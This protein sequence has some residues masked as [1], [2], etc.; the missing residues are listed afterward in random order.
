MNVCTEITS[1]QLQLFVYIGVKDEDIILSPN[2]AELSEQVV[3]RFSGNDYIE[4]VV[5]ETFQRDQ[6]LKDLRQHQAEENQFFFNIRFRTKDNGVL[7]FVSGQ[8]GSVTLKVGV[9][10]NSV[11]IA[12]FSMSN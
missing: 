10:P 2:C 5:K 7:L 4:Y 11:N 9:K 6:L 8:T 3:L 12:V 1:E